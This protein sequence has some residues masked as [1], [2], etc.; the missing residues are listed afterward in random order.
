MDDS[1]HKNELGNLQ[2]DKKWSRLIIGGLIVLAIFQ[3]INIMR[4]S[5][6]TKI[7]Q[8]TPWGDRSKWIQG[9]K[10]SEAKL[11]ELGKWMAHLNLDVNERTIGANTDI[12]LNWTDGSFAEQV[13]SKS[14]AA[15]RRLRQYAASTEFEV[16]SAFPDTD[17]LRVAMRG[18]LTTRI[19]GEPNPAELKAYVAEFKFDSGRLVLK[20]WYEAASADD[21]LGLRKEP[22]KQGPVKAV[23]AAASAASSAIQAG[24]K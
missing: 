17:K 20:D 22:G 6:R 16:L 4:N 15:E 2:K 10:V 7:I 19:S 24:G 1:I 8:E 18:N 9:S 12:L 23:E 5:D 13:R 21:P 14:K 11:I 3:Q